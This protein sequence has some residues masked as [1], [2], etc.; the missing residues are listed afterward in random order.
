M[1]GV[2]YII[3]YIEGLLLQYG[4]S[5]NL[6]LLASKLLAI[7]II[8]IICFIADRIT[9]KVLFRILES[10]IMKT[11]NKWDDML[12]ENN[13]LD[14]IGRIP[15]ALV[16]YAFAPV[17]PT[18]EV[19]I[20]RIAFIYIL[21]NVTSVIFRILDSLNDILREH[22]TFKTRPT[23]GYI[24]VVKIILGVIVIIIV[25]SVLMNR[26]PLLLLSGLGAATAVL[27]LIFQNSLLG[28]VASIQLS[29]NNMVEIGD[30]IDM[31]AHNANGDVLDIS[32][33]T[34][35]VQNWDKT[36]TTIPTHLLIS[37]SFKNWKGMQE[38]GGRR[39]QRSI[40][41]DVNSIK[42]VDEDMLERL[43]EIQLIK[44]YIKN[45]KIELD[46]YN[47]DISI[48]E[49]NIV[50]YRHLTNIGT[51]RVYIEEYIKSHPKINENMTR[52]VRQLQQTDKG[53]PIEIYAYANQV[54][55]HDYEH[56]QSDIFEH[57]LSIVHE[58]DLR[59][60][61]SPTGHDIKYVS[62]NKTLN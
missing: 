15:A 36:I 33:H 18:F 37:E 13:T 8:I 30:W 62:E 24:Q 60:Y 55:W 44:D 6:S 51:F 5:E 1:I 4:V 43:E 11:K 59:I 49:E 48:D 20:R 46:K 23:K 56:I 21:I 14:V 35:K 61:Q 3:D 19:W 29:S 50:N 9:K 40:Y 17:F 26:S 47:K 2:I 10:H 53:V 12:L 45:K 58:F 16:I 27:M 54:A 38:S 28:F 52:V 31:P 7:G 25:V 39:I 42:F 57:I 32:L 34:V 41:I 22:P